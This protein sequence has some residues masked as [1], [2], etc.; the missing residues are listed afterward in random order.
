MC[1][2]NGILQ[3][4]KRD[5]KQL[6]DNLS[7]MNKLIFHRGPDDDGFYITET[8]SYN[9]GMA[10]RRLSIIDLSTGKQPM[11]NDNKS[12]VIVFNGEIYNYK[13]LKQKLEDKGVTFKTKSDTEV[14]LRLYETFGVDSFKQLDGMYAFSIHDKNKNKLFIARDFFGE[15]PLYYFKN[16]ERFLWASELKSIIKVL[17][18][19]PA[20]SK[21]GVNLFFQL[22]YIPAPYT[23]YDNINK[24][25]SNHY[26]DYD[27][28]SNT[29]DIIE[30]NSVTKTHDTL[31][32][33]DDAKSKTKAL[34]QQS[35]ASRSIADVPIGTFLSGGVDS[36]I[37]SYCLSEMSTNNIETFSIGFEK[38]SFDETD[39]SRL[40]SKLIHSNHH[41]FI[42]SEDDIS[43]DLDLIL[44]NFDEPFADAA[45]LPTYIMSK[46]TRQHVKVALTGDGGDE[47]FGGYNKYYIGKLNTKYSKL[48]PES[49]HKGIKGPL[50]KLLSTKNDDRASG[51]RTKLKKLV[52]AVNYEG[53]YYWNIISLGFGDTTNS[54]L[55]SDYSFDDTLGYYKDKTG[56]S[57]PSTLHQYRDIDRY[58]SL[59]GDMLPKVDRVSMLNSIECR[60]PFLNKTLWDFTNSLPDH[61][62]LKGWS[63][64]HLLKEA[65]KDDFPE[66]FLEKSK[67]GF[68]VPTGDWLRSSLKQEVTSYLEP[69]FLESQGIFNPE[70]ITHIMM[71][72]INGKEDNSYKAWAFYCFQKWYYNN[73]LGRI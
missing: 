28:A 68:A 27:L 44:S 51:K 49:I 38:K 58:L 63:K 29:I 10:M 15:K 46:Q 30:I 47:V 61:Y 56:I 52:D 5:K 39:K 18:K 35:V 22:T 45:A 50:Q 12:I 57:N 60:A 43:K 26:I 54:I 2:I 32:S 66:G 4:Q 16:N 11:Y 40:V 64:K 72:H 41:E 59:E 69:K 37:I 1:G 33:F 48:I 21:L 23:I 19:K 25:S 55:T 31:L 17:D 9:L 24:L 67:K 13:I 7:I 34:V 3:I 36:S 14:I 62:L 65:F 73:Y 53:N 20:I 42:V 8:K 71:N 6:A 70:R